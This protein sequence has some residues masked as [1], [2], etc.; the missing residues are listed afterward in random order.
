M[1]KIDS[2]QKDP[3]QTINLFQE[4]Q[5]HS[6]W[7][8]MFIIVTTRDLFFYQK[9]PFNSPKDPIEKHR[10]LWSLLQTRLI[11]LNQNLLISDRCSKNDNDVDQ[12]G[13]MSNKIDKFDRIIKSN[14]SDSIKSFP[15]SL[16]DPSDDF[17]SLN[18]TNQSIHQRHQSIEFVLRCGSISGIQTRLF[19]AQFHSQLNQFSRQLIRS[20]MFLV[21]QL[22]QISFGRLFFLDFKYKFYLL[23][24]T[25]FPFSCLCSMYIA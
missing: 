22:Q 12:N 17:Y 8:P 10:E 9:F 7:R 3:P 19:Q 2:S 6:K 24:F 18:S 4:Y 11:Y 16:H 13:M 23:I 25:Y 1:M 20:Q 5:K 14:E 15:S 21:K